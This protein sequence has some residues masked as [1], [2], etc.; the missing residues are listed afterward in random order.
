MSRV[1]Q[2]ELGF[3]SDVKHDIDSEKDESY[4]RDVSTPPAPFDAEFE[5]KTMRKV[6]LRLLPML[7]ALYSF[8]LIDRTNLS[9]VRLNGAGVDLELATGNHYSVTNLVFF[10]PYILLELPSN[11]AFRRVGAALWLGSIAFL[12]GVVMLCMGFV[13]TWQ[14]LAGL[15]GLLGILEAGFFPACV[16]VISCWYTRR[17]LQVRMASFYLTLFSQLPQDSVILIALYRSV[18]LGS[19]ANILAYGLAQIKV[20]TMAGWRWIFIVEGLIT[21]VLAVAGYILICDFPDKNK[22]LTP[23]QTA[24]I[25]ERVQRDRG[26]AVHDPLTWAKAGKYALDL[27]LWAF[28]I[29]FMCATMPAY[30]Y[31]YFFPI[32]LRG[33]GFSVRDSQIL[34]APPGVTAAISGLIIGRFADRVNKRG[35]FIVFQACLAI[36]GLCMTAFSHTTGVRFAGGFLTYAGAQGNIPAI[37]SYQSNNIRGQSKRAFTSALVVGFGGIGGIFASTSYREQDYPNYLIGLWC[38]L[39][40]QFATIAIIAMTS[41]WFMYR[42]NQVRRGVG[43]PIEG[44]PGFLYTL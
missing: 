43:K 1:T 28:A 41:T 36:I 14:Q 13:N 29:L 16:Y 6:D 18:F 30:A 3:Q 11:L 26:D 37:L 27:K 15:R 44:L 12:W 40:C 31:A 9:N 2:P 33:M 7:G 35:P 4:H 32:I 8:A 19:F 24:L 38:T 34:S 17:E 20:G 23:E 25:K 21:I 22:F 39:G 10:I 5:K 42:N